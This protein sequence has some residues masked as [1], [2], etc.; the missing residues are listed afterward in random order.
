MHPPLIF[1]GW[2]LVTGNYLSS[3]APATLCRWSVSSHDDGKESGLIHRC[4][5]CPPRWWPGWVGK[6]RTFNTRWFQSSTC[7]SQARPQVHNFEVQEPYTAEFHLGPSW[8]LAR[9][10]P[11]S[12]VTWQVKLQSHKPLPPA[13]LCPSHAAASWPVWDRSAQPHWSGWPW[14]PPESRWAMTSEPRC[15][16]FPSSGSPASSPTGRPCCRTPWTLWS[17]YCPPCSELVWRYYGGRRGPGWHTPSWPVSAHLHRTA[18][19]SGFLFW[20]LSDSWSI[21]QIKSELTCLVRADCTN[22]MT[23]GLSTS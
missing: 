17:S 1:A 13:L 2:A 18:C 16:W 7:L 5:C 10:S 14:R 20:L 22:V 12:L 4:T 8:L 3:L 15:L 23:D 21:I 11:L 19:P 9:I 6:R